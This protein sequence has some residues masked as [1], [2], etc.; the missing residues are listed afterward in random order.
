M[1]NTWQPY[2]LP[3]HAYSIG[4]VVLPTTWMGYLWSCTTA[5]TSGASEPAWPNPIG[6]GLETV[7]DGG[8]TWTINSGFRE[9]LQIGLVN[10][11]TTFMNANPTILHSVL[12]Q[13]PKSVNQEL[14]MLYVG[15]IAES[16]TIMHDIW[17]RELRAEVFYVDVQPDPAEVNDRQNFVID[18]LTPALVV[19]FHSANPRSITSP[20]T[21]GDY[22]DEDEAFALYARIRWELSGVITEGTIS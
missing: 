10:T 3:N 17:T 13:R 4:A 19:A 15:D 6:T 18:A 5:G 14:P 20:V 21:V 9:A 1:S 2:W 22:Q 11:G 12:S 16:D 8:V 7:T